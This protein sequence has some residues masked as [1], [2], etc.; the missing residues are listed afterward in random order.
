MSVPL[1][2]Q[3][4][5]DVKMVLWQTLDLERW[6]QPNHMGAFSAKLSALFTQGFGTDVIQKNFNYAYGPAQPNEWIAIYSLVPLPRQN[7]HQMVQQWVNGIESVLYYMHTNPG[8]KIYNVCKDGSSRFPMKNL[9]RFIIRHINLAQ[10]PL[11][12]DVYL[13]NLYFNNAFLLYAGLGFRVIQL[14]HEEST[15]VMRYQPNN[16]IISNKDALVDYKQRILYDTEQKILKH[17]KDTR[18]HPLIQLLTPMQQISLRELTEHQKRTYS[19]SK[20]TFT[21]SQQSALSNITPDQELA[22]MSLHK[23]IFLD[24]RVKDLLR[25]NI[26]LEEEVLHARSGNQPIPAIYGIF[27]HGGIKDDSANRTYTRGDVTVPPSFVGR[28][29][30]MTYNKMGLMLFT[31]PVHQPYLTD[32]M[33]IPNDILTVPTIANHEE[34]DNNFPN[35]ELG[36]DPVYDTRVVCKRCN[37]KKIA[38]IYQD[39]TL[40]EV[41]DKIEAHHNANHG[42]GQ[43]QINCFFCTTFLN[44]SIAKTYVDKFFMYLTWYIK[45]QFQKQGK[46]MHHDIL[47]SVSSF[48]K[49]NR[50]VLPNDIQKLKDLQTYIIEMLKRTKILGAY[51]ESRGAVLASVHV[52][53]YAAER[54][55]IKI[56]EKYLEKYLSLVSIRLGPRAPNVSMIVDAQ[57]DDTKE[58]M[59]M[60]D[61]DDV[62]DIDAHFGRSKP[63]RGKSKRVRKHILLKKGRTSKR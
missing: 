33:H 37:N 27:C 12:L 52:A 28:V 9:I 16:P 25:I 51:G 30:F 21:P 14:K 59:E 60:V 29:K 40:T 38:S 6:L 8:Y 31:E 45:Y 61:V 36:Q 57:G 47:Y 11:V 13:Y 48:I 20:L 1:F 53:D 46:L 50:Y 34:Y 2:T 15:L 54:I 10:E 42:P 43:I 5:N 4:E 55:K 7:D 44:D 35:M 3:D 17:A 39:T 22:I 26:P 19:R 18:D 41:L 56:C 32:P 49:S 58:D 63:K 23:S 24:A 62:M